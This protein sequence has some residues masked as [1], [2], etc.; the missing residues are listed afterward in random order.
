VEAKQFFFSKKNQK[1]FVL[2]VRAVGYD[3][4][5]ELKVFCF[6]SSE[7]KVFFLWYSGHAAQARCRR[8]QSIKAEK[9]T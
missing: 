8:R 1:T 6:F 4:D 7:K 2:L 3:R 5:S 9:R